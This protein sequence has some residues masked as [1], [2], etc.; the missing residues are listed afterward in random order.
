M[1]IPNQ[2]LAEW[3]TK[4]LL[5]PISRDVSMGGV[6]T[7]EEAISRAQ[8]FYFVYSQSATLYKLIPNSTRTPTNP[9]KPSSTTHVDGVI[10][11]IKNQYSS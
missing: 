7:E 11:T 4:S 1:T 2:L 9:S 8:Y 10:S 5:P 3:F 6:V